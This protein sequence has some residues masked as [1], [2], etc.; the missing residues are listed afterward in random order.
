MARKGTLTERLVALAIGFIIY[1]AVYLSLYALVG[2]DNLPAGVLG[3]LWVVSVVAGLF[4]SLVA[5]LTILKYR[6]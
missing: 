4:G 5:G 2:G 1:G 3:L 6:K